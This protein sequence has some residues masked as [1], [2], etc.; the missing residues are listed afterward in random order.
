[1]R[2]RPGTWNDVQQL[3]RDTE[4][5]ADLF[6]NHV[7]SQSPQFANNVVANGSDSPW[8]PLF[9]TYNSVFPD[10]AREEEITA[11]YRP[12]PSLPYE[13]P[14]VQLLM[15]LIRW[16]LPTGPKRRPAEPALG[17]G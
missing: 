7:S 9:L 4:V 1:M 10:S 5:M 16:C 13:R 8:F 14:V 3:S 17:E 2:Q 15:G 6:V 12:Q 11:I